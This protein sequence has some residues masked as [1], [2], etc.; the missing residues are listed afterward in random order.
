[1]ND[2]KVCF[3][4]CVNNQIR[5]NRSLE[6]VKLLKIP[7]GFETEYIFITGASSMTAGYN[8]AMKKSDAKYKIY[9]HQDVLIINRNFIFDIISLFEKYPLLGML[10]VLGVKELPKDGVWWNG[11]Q[12]FGNLY[13]SSPGTMRLLSCLKIEGDFESVEVIDG[14]IMMTQVDLP[15]RSD[16]FDS[17]HFYDTSQ[18]LEFIK[19]GYEVGI[20]KQEQPWVIHDCG[21]INYTGYEYYRNIFVQNYGDRFKLLHSYK[22]EV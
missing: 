18:S 16:L 21:L 5:L 20:A 1:M 10:G 15:W 19:A 3:I 9:L 8:E 2:K 4:Y 13:E 17:W 22:K 7:K 14:L 11:D 6:T 12:W